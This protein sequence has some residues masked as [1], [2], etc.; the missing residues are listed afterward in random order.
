[1]SEPFLG[2]IR[3]FGF[4]FAPVGW[5]QCNGQLMAISQNTALFSLLGTQF[6]GDGVSTFA[7]PNL[8]SRVAVHVGQGA[9]LSQYV[10]G[11]QTGVENVALTTL[12]MPTHSHN[13]NCNGSATATGGSVFG[14]GNGAT[15]VG[16]YPGLAASPSNAVYASAPGAGNLMNAGMIQPVGNSQGHENLQPLLVVNF[17]IAL[18]GIFPSRN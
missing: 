15:P 6:G 12:Q 3:M 4:N 14:K 11:E 5:A 17:C 8:Q 16:N 1:M 10:M 2:E 9:G 13:V 18:E 7:L